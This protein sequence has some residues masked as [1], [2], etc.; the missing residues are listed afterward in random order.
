MENQKAIK[1][2]SQ[3]NRK[4]ISGTLFLVLF[5]WVFNGI[6]GTLISF[7][8]SAVFYWLLD[9]IGKE[10]EFDSATNERLRRV[11][12][13]MIAGALIV[14]SILAFNSKN[15]TEC[16]QQVRT[17]DGYECV[18][19]YVAVKGGDVV[20]GVLL[21]IFGIAAAKVSITKADSEA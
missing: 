9:R 18:G 11:V 14:G 15:H 21:A 17:R 20:A 8:L 7:G 16:D 13:G 5:L 2:I 4:L 19:D 1:G 12:W 6:Y 10:Y 3:E